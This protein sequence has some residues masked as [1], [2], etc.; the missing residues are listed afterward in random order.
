MLRRRF[1]TGTLAAPVGL[2]LP[3]RPLDGSQL[4]HVEFHPRYGEFWSL[5]PGRH[6]AV[7][8]PETSDTWP[9]LD[10]WM[11]ADR[12][13]VRP[14]VGTY[15]VTWSLTFQPGGGT[16]RKCALEHYH[17]DAGEW[18]DAGDGNEVPAVR[19]GETTLVG[20]RWVK[21]A[22]GDRLRVL[23]QHDSDRAV[24]MSDRFYE[25]CLHLARWPGQFI[26]AHGNATPTL[27]SF[28]HYPESKS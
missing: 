10:G 12:T 15:F 17:A 6:H 14:P 8:W 25:S 28:L 26:P 9:D 1:L 27:H 20:A 23:A 21:A 4:T 5:P 18:A 22:D 2:L 11:S 13:E 19:K 7:P 3:A 24:R 16:E